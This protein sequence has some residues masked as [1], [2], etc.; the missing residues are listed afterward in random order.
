MLHHKLPS[1][2]SCYR[3]YYESTIG[4]VNDITQERVRQIVT[5]TIQ[6]ISDIAS[7]TQQAAAGQLISLA[8]VVDESSIEPNDRISFT[9]GDVFTVRT[10]NCLRAEGYRYLDQ[11][12]L[13][14]RD[15]LLKIPKMGVKSANEVYD[16]MTKLYGFPMQNWHE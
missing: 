16:V 12:A 1:L 7:S 3:L 14:S 15:V 5:R 2:L 13:L 10:I 9:N 6:Q 4:E 11:L 8:G